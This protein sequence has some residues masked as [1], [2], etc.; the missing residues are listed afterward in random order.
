MDSR[1]GCIKP[2]RRPIIYEDSWIVR[3]PRPYDPFPRP[4]PY[5]PFE[6]PFPW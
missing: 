3:K 1:H 5:D 2:I 6:R 4:K